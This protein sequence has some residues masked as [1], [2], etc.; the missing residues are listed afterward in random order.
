MISTVIMLFLQS[1]MWSWFLT[2]YLLTRLLLGSRSTLKY[3]H[4]EDTQKREIKYVQPKTIFSLQNCLS[5]C[6]FLN[7]ERHHQRFLHMVL[8][9]LFPR[10][11]RFLSHFSIDIKYILY[12]F[13]LLYPHSFG[14][15]LGHLSFSARW[16]PFFFNVFF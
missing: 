14:L 1:P 9:L 3:I 11:N 15:T 5:F 6:Y 8:Y 10:Y 12:L 16:W 4:P 7:S 2:M 13:L